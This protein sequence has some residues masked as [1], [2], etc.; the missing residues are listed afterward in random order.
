MRGAGLVSSTGSARWPEDR[1]VGLAPAFFVSGELERM[2]QATPLDKRLEEMLSPTVTAMGYE[3]VRVRLSGQNRRTLQIMAERPDGTM[4]VD[5]CADLSRALSALL[6]VEDPISGEYDLQVSSPGIDRPLTR[7]KDFVNWS[8]HE[9]KLELIHG[10]DG[11][12]RF[13]GLLTGLEGSHVLMDVQADGGETA[14][15]RLPFDDLAEARLVITDA[16]LKDAQSRA[17]RS[18]AGRR[19]D[20]TVDGMTRPRHVAPHGLGAGGIAEGMD[21]EPGDDWE[22]DESDP[23]DAD[24][25]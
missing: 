3:M 14:S 16:L 1:E 13:K 11:R 2:G 22:L 19:D 15:V 12:R 18:E 20:P 8:G 7:L 23:D 5:D 9:A 21:I 6:D 10:I 17:A 4:G 24:P 25:K